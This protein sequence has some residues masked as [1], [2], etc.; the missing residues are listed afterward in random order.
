MTLP[1]DCS[2]AGLVAKEDWLAI[3]AAELRRTRRPMCLTRARSGLGAVKAS[4]SASE[5]PL[6]KGCQAVVMDRRDH[7][8]R[9]LAS[10]GFPFPQRRY[11]EYSDEEYRTWHH[12]LITRKFRWH[13]LGT[14]EVRAA[15]RKLRLFIRARISC[16]LTN[17]RCVVNS[18][19]SSSTSSLGYPVSIGRCCTA[20]VA[21]LVGICANKP[22]Q[23]YGLIGTTG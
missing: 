18:H 11:S 14:P 19:Y 1:V 16:L 7:A 17:V 21:G 4:D 22:S 10:L 13:K 6:N 3:T 20:L 12:A 15:L 9:F 23:W 8:C 2:R 5:T